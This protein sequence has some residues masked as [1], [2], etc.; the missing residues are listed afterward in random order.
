MVRGIVQGVGYR[1]SAHKFAKQLGI[2]GFV[3]N[4]SDGNVLIIAEGSQVQ[5]NTLVKWCYD[6]PSRARV[7]DVIQLD[8][9]FEGFDSFN[10][11]Y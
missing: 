9:E 5:I 10:I 7:S 1:H 2:K 8:K 4:Q 3:K 11:H 6:G